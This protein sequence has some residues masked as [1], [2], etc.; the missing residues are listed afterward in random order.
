MIE[1]SGPARS[2]ARSWWLAGVVGLTMLACSQSGSDATSTGAVDT[3]APTV[4]QTTDSVSL[5]ADS[6]A[7][8]P[9][10][11]QQ[12]DVAEQPDS[13]T[14]QP[15]PT[16]APAH[17]Y[18]APGS[19][20]GRLTSETHTLWLTVPPTPVGALEDSSHRLWLWAGAPR[21]N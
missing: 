11:P 3:G 17:I 13:G 16:G 20:G 19:A 2:P 14:T 12:G 1:R 7:P 8:A 5:I 21:P 15:T 4:F 18:I 10:A 6:E 9:D